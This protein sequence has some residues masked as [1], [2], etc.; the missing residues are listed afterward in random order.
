MKEIDSAKTVGYAAIH[1]K[2]N[3]IQYRNQVWKDKVVEKIRTQK[4]QRKQEEM[5]QCTF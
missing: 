4:E 1:S 5:K 3:L 2:K